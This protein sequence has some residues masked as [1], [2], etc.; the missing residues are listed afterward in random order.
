MAGRSLI[1][2]FPKGIRDTSPS[3]LGHRSR[4]HGRYPKHSSG[5]EHVSG[6]GQ[7]RV[8]LFALWVG[9]DG[10]HH[11]AAHTQQVANLPVDGTEVLSAPAVGEVSSPVP[12]MIQRSS[13]TLHLVLFMQPGRR[14]LHLVLRMQL[15][16]RI[17]HLVLATQPG[18]ADSAPSIAHAS[19]TADSA[20]SA[21]H[22]TRTADP[23]P[24]TAQAART[25]VLVGESETSANTWITD[26]PSYSSHY[27]TTT[28]LNHLF[29]RS[30]CWS[31]V[32]HHRV[33]ISETWL[34]N[35]VTQ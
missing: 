24:S 1:L 11:T 21:E 15:G 34:P 35:C 33:P 10:L 8:L 9:S 12:P 7:N 3:W 5:T 30:A 31:K 13:L 26:G 16:Q 28:W 20:P 29:Y 25:A 32:Q 6:F 4:R 23:A 14:N 19:R 27:P 18:T 22:T 2:W 17:L